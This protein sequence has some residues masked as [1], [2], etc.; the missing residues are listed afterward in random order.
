M[1]SIVVDLRVVCSLS[2]QPKA[3][4]GSSKTQ[5]FSGDDYT[6]RDKF[7]D[8]ERNSLD[9]AGHP[10]IRPTKTICTSVVPDDHADRRHHSQ[11]QIEALQL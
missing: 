5:L 10:N 7:E 6:C 3:E 4:I 8:R 2:C 9:E 1:T 11:P